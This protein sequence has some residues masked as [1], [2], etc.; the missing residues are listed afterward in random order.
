MDS[1]E[2][3]HTLLSN[4]NYD[5]APIDTNIEFRYDNLNELASM[6]SKD[7][8]NGIANLHKSMASLTVGRGRVRINV[9]K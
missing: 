1:Q 8:N 3:L 4:A 5:V 7:L 2:S 9:S 6:S